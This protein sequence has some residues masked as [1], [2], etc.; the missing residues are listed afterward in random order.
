[1]SGDSAS[2]Y[3]LQNRAANR[4][5]AVAGHMLE[6]KVRIN[7]QS[8][9]VNLEFSWAG[10]GEASS[11]SSSSTPASAP[12]PA[13]AKEEKPSTSEAATPAASGAPE[14]KT[15]EYTAEEVAKH[16]TKD[17]C[18]VIVDGQVLDVTSVSSTT[19]LS[20]C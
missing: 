13:P 4:L 20:S 9:T 6:T 10:Q 11:S 17:D 5:G 14:K 18:W 8:S 1:M 16:N 7:P 3:L 15:G 2:S 19:S 12:A